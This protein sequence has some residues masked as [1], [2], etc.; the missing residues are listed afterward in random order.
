MA[1][2]VAVIKSQVQHVHKLVT[3]YQPNFAA[4]V[5]GHIRPEAFVELAIAYVKRDPDLLHAAQ[6]NPQS[7]IL[8]LRE[9]G[10]L[11]HLPMKGT[12]SLTAF[13]DK[14]APGGKAIVGM[15]EW[16]GVVER[17]YR[18]GGVESVHVEVG[19]DNDRVLRFNRTRDVLPDH[20]YDEFAPP[21]VRGPLKVVYAW[22]RLRTGGTSQV[23]WLPRYEVLRH[24]SMSRSAQKA[25]GG[26]F[27]GPEDGEGPNT[28]AMWR[29]T[30]LHV[31]EGFVPTSAEYRWQAAA[32]ESGA[33][34]WAGVP[35]RPVTQLYGG[36]GDLI[37]AE[38]TDDTAAAATGWPAVPGPGSGQLPPKEQSN[39]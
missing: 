27:W 14:N 24:R 15:E 3:S 17:I 23:A 7:L 4:M 33:R 31:L 13:N 8:V 5:P 29:K 35:D 21:S 28:E 20:E 16:R 2:D 10:A 9:C 25:G 34:G 37:D 19:R 22:A 32:A 11:G 12:F 1:T 39:V 6:V 36:S 18:A 26:N 38:F 30:A